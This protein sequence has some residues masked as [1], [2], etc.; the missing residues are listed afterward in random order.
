MR[1]LWVIFS[2][3]MKSIIGIVFVMVLNLLV[4]DYINRVSPK[5]GPSFAILH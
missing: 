2:I 1:I 3:E 5:I 4:V